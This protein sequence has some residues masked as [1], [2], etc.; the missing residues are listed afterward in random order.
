MTGKLVCA[1]S[2]LANKAPRDAGVSF[3]FMG[4]LSVKKQR[5]SAIYYLHFPAS[6]AGSVVLRR[7][8]GREIGDWESRQAHAEHIAFARPGLF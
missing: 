6:R 3:V 2:A 5:I 4:F 1:G 8:G 7:L